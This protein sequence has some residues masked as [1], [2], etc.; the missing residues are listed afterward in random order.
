MYYHQDWGYM[1]TKYVVNESGKFELGG[2]LD[3]L[4][5]FATNPS[6]HTA[7]GFPRFLPLLPHRQLYKKQELSIFIL[8]YLRLTSRHT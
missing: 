4:N 6:H 8:M 2:S 7:T 5:P 3:L 1:F